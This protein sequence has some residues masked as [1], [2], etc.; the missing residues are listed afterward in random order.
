MD[1]V[2]VSGLVSHLR[3]ALVRI[4]HGIELTDPM[5]EQ[6]CGAYPEIMANCRAACVVLHRFGDVVSDDEIS[7]VAA[8]F[9]ASLLRLSESGAVR[10]TIR[11]GVICVHGIGS[12]YLLASQVKKAFGTR[13][14]VE[15]GWYDDTEQW[16][17]YDVL[18]STTELVDTETPVIV[19]RPILAEDDIRRINEA[20]IS[21]RIDP[22]IP[23]KAPAAFIEDLRKL[24]DIL[25]GAAD[26]IEHFSQTTLPATADIGEMATAA[27]GMF[28]KTRETSDMIA[29]GLTARKEIST[30][31]VKEL[32]IVLLHCR[33]SG[34]NGP[35]FGV[36]TPIGDV[37]VNSPFR[38][39]QVAVIMLIPAVASR[40]L[41]EMMGSLSAALIERERF[42]H[43]LQ[44]GTSPI[45]QE[46]L[47]EVLRDYLSNISNQKLKG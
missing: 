25:S 13:V 45:I 28:G 10:R 17:R 9:G 5:R 6:M 26:L 46:E 37:F 30:Q 22:V 20:L 14:A 34:V 32:R 40:E 31:A 23:E 19:T 44:T 29:A 4:R 43:A 2:L 36:M 42:L 33:T 18:V 11:V 27:G 3:T 35:R 1:E 41:S 24:G 16:S 7:L 12:S 15:V 47:S 38:D 39:L 8:H 21:R